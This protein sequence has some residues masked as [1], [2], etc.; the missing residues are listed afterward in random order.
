MKKDKRI[1]IT[2]ITDYDGIFN[3]DDIVEDVKE[4]KNVEIEVINERLADLTIIELY[5]TR[6]ETDCEHDDRIYLENIHEQNKIKQEKRQL[7]AFLN[8]HGL[9]EKWIVHEKDQDKAAKVLSAENERLKQD[10]E[11]YKEKIE[12]IKGSIDKLC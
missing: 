1:F 11:E 2:S 5:Y 6:P 8:K 7:V 9:P 12:K 10:L 3:F 4:H